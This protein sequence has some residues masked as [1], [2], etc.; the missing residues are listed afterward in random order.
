M[1]VVSLHIY[2]VK[3]VRAFDVERVQLATRGLDGD[4][5]W[6]VVDPA[7]TF[8]TQ[9]SHPRLAAIAATPTLAGL[10]LSAPDMADLVL[11]VPDGR[12][13]LAVTI[14]KHGV[15]AALAD[16]RAGEWLS[17]F[18][19]EA[20]RLV[21]M[22]DRAE[23]L[24]IGPW[25]EVAIPVSFADGYPVLVTTASSLT[26]L[27]QEI[28]RGGGAAVTMRRFRPNIVLDAAAPWAEDF[29]KTLRIGKTEIDLVKPCDRCV[30]TTKDQ[31]TGE[32]TGEEPLTTLRRLRMSADPRVKGVL[33]G[34]NAVPRLLGEI[35]IGD[36]VEIIADR[37]EGFPLHTA[38]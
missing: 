16:A 3:G 17:R 6:L 38:A 31:L 5:R 4:R 30:V 19:G 23:R 24:Q 11:E 35:A 1:R 21:Y 37:A 36:Q 32:T 29:W 7:G 22:D 18:F 2:P 28:E 33:F 34:W 20:L 27:N 13:R 25:S 9:R 8:A 10:R 15:D 12:E 26:R 14:W